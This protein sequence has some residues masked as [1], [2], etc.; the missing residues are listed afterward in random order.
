MSGPRD[1]ERLIGQWVEKAEEDLRAAE[2]LLDIG[3]GCPFSA[4]AFHAQQSAEKYLKALLVSESVP[5]PR[6][7][8][9]GELVQLF[10]PRNRP[11]IPIPTQE[12]LTD[13]ATVSRYP[14]GGGASDARRRRG[15]NRGGAEGA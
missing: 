5:F 4:V 15:G 8:D 10:P 9:I 3:E 13:Y 1:R 12:R 11:P 2:Y 14:G 7:H 6:I